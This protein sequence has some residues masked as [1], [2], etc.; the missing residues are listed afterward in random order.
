MT[1]RAAAKKPKLVRL[2]VEP[3][4]TVTTREVID[5]ASIPTTTEPSPDKTDFKKAKFNDIVLADEPTTVA[6]NNKNLKTKLQSVMGIS[7]LKL[8]TD[9]VRA[10]AK[11]LGI[12]DIR[13]A[14]KFD[15]CQR[16]VEWVS[17]KSNEIVDVTSP[18]DDS[19]NTSNITINRRRYL[20]VIFSDTVRPLIATKGESLNKDDLTSGLKQDQVLLTKIAEEYNKP[21]PE[22]AAD[23]HP[24]I[25][26]GRYS[27]AGIYNDID[28]QKSKRVFTQLSNEY[29]K[30]FWNWKKSGFHGEFPSEE[31]VEPNSE[32]LPFSDF[33]HG[34]C[35][36]ALHAPICAFFS[37][38]SPVNYRYVY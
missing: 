27:D 11:A 31:G 26:K 13:K 30:A 28:W 15:V 34:N 4:A 12:K 6:N 32:K 8:S 18:K 7:V 25:E 1:K 10:T 2:V 21:I 29:D 17:D 20:N 5:V 9:H 23:A 33:V 19:P 38:L 3:P 22:Y 16:I 24:E 37:Q 14:K 35:L 36:F